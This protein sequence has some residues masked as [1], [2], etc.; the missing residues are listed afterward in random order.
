MRVFLTQRKPFDSS[1]ASLG[2][3]RLRYSSTLVV[4]PVMAL[5]MKEDAVLDA[6]RATHHARD[7][8]MKAPSRGTGDSC[9]AHRA[10]SAKIALALNNPHQPVLKD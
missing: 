5:R 4:N 1:T 2:E 9:I 6:A 8:V 7:A 3:M 10:E